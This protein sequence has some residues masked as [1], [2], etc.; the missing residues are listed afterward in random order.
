MARS[1]DG[2]S[3]ERE[4]GFTEAGRRLLLFGGRKYGPVAN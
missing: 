3:I 2:D 4:S 1:N